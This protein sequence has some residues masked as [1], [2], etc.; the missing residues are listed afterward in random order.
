MKFCIR[1][2][3][4][5]SLTFAVTVSAES[6]NTILES[7]KQIQSKIEKLRQQEIKS[8]LKMSLVSKEEVLKFLKVRISEEYTDAEF[9]R[10]E[11]QAKLFGLIPKDYDYRAELQ[12]IMVEQIGGYYDHRKQ[13]L[14]IANWISPLMQKP[15]LA[16][17]IFHAVQVQEW[18]AGT[19]LD[20]QR[21][22]LDALL[23]HQALMEGDATIVMAH[24]M[25]ADQVPDDE[26]LNKI[27]DAAIK[28]SMSSINLSAASAKLLGMSGTFANAPRHIKRS[29]VMPYA[30]GARFILELREKAKWSWSQIND[31]YKNPPRTTTQIL[32]PEKYWK[33]QTTE[34]IVPF[35]KSKP[36]SWKM[37]ERN[38]FGVLMLGES[39]N[40]NKA[41]DIWPENFPD[42]VDDQVELFEKKGRFAARLRVR[43]RTSKSAQKFV[44]RWQE[45][46]RRHAGCL[47]SVAG[48]TVSILLA[49]GHSDAVELEKELTQ[50]TK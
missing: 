38:T 25:V 44:T 20:R 37:V 7:A 43:W 6:P 21:F 22:Q 27:F 36:S 5:L 11:A 8:E 30:V 4:L 1:V 2:I 23:A 47:L 3:F 16:H 35:P 41:V 9:T 12:K 34:K 24:Y 31:V 46:Y 10:I 28:S 50:K 13:A 40:R 33:G 42:W 49:N 39:L 26:T 17:E 18:D 48:T 19:L 29:L 45:S 32:M 14:Y 15:V